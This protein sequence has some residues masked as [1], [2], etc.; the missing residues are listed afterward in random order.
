MHRSHIFN[1]YTP[2]FFDIVLVLT[3]SYEF[4][5]SVYVDYIVFVLYIS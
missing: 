1:I 5:E 2:L 4:K 3:Y